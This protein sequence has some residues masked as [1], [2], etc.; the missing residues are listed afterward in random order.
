MFPWD[1][2][3]AESNRRKHGLS[4]EEAV[5]AFADGDA[6]DSPDLRH[7]A[8]ETRRLLIGKLPGGRIITVAYTRREADD[9]ETTTRVISAR[10]ASSEE[11]AAR[12]R[13]RNRLL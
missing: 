1:P 2:A 11:R 6:L 7:S 3:K 4:F 10:Q 12:A 5:N 8:S 9:G 13:Q